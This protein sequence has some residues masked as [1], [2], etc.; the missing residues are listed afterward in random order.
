MLIHQRKTVA[1]IKRAPDPVLLEDIENHLA[2]QAHDHVH[3]TC[4]DSRPLCG[5]VD[6]ETADLVAPH[7]HKAEDRAVPLED[8]GFGIA[9]MDVQDLSLFPDQKRVGENGGC[10]PALL[11]SLQPA[12][13]AVN[14]DE[15]RLVAGNAR[16]P[17]F[18]RLPPP[19]QVTNCAVGR[20]HQPL[21]LAWQITIRGGGYRIQ[22]ADGPS[23]TLALV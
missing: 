21:A 23:E 12:R 11:D 3:K 15:D 7:R 17:L 9:K 20:T 1:A 8:P 19:P 2:T 6:E 18:G 5:R 10:D 13:R 14:P 16:Q 4:A 22:Q